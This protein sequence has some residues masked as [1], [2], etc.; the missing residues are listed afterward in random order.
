MGTKESMKELKIINTLNSD[1]N[2][3]NKDFNGKF[4]N[5][6][7]RDAKRRNSITGNNTF[8]KKENNELNKKK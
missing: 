7:K 2:R 1:V 8:N 4:K 6:Y 5:V 3:S